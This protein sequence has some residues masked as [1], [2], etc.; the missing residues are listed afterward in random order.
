MGFGEPSEPSSEILP[1]VQPEQDVRKTPF[2]GGNRVISIWKAVAF[3]F[4]M[5][6]IAPRATGILVVFPL[7]RSGGI[8][9]TGLLLLAEFVNFG[10][11]LGVSLLVSRL[12][13]RSIGEY[14]LP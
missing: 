13:S 7:N 11:L 5:I 6:E 10:V 14:G 3:L 1:A 12:E 9:P 4:V 2:L 8:S